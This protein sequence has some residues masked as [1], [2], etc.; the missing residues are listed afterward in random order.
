MSTN[1]YNSV[2]ELVDVKTAAAI[3]TCSKSKL[4]NDRVLK[5]GLPYYR[6]GNNVRYKVSDILAAIEQSRVE[7]K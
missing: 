5:R 3:F 2:D 7:H 6:L 4:D 1:L